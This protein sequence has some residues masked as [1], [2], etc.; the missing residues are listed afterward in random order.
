MAELSDAFRI[1]EELSRI[2][3]LLPSSL[4]HYSWEKILE[5]EINAHPNYYQ[6]S[7]LAYPLN[8]LMNEGQGVEKIISFLKSNSLVSARNQQKENSKRMIDR[9]NEIKNNFSS[10]DN[11]RYSVAQASVFAMVIQWIA[12]FYIQ[13]TLKIIEMILPD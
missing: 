7:I 11:G 8:N 12:N 2:L 9:H 10:K 13:N 6:D 4:I 1:H 5:Y 3:I